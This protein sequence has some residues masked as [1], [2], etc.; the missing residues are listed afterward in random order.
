[1]PLLFLSSLWGFGA[2][3]RRRVKSGALW[4]A[5]LGTLAVTGG[6]M[7]YGYVA[8]RYTNE[9]LPVLIL[10]GAIGTVDIA[11]RIGARGMPVKRIAVGVTAALAAFGVFASMAIGVHAARTTYRGDSLVDFVSLQARTADVTGRLDDL[12]AVADAV[13]ADGPTDH[14]LILGDCDALYLATGDAYE[15]WIAVQSR[16]YHVRIRPIADS[17]Q[18][19]VLRLI[20][21]NGLDRRSIYLEGDGNGRIRLRMGE[22]YVFYPSDWIEFEAGQSLDVGVRLDTTVNRYLIELDGE[23]VG[24]VAASETDGNA[25]MIPAIPSFALPPE[26]DRAIVGYALTPEMGPR[27]ELCDRVLGAVDGDA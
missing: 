26:L 2:M 13:P 23:E 24:Y 14:L 11:Q 12:V 17:F 7:F 8:H 21:I 19:G 15:P 25:P 6:V 22:G 4:I 9:F 18:Y 27:L 5:L 1:M 10:G 3:V 20:D 16:E